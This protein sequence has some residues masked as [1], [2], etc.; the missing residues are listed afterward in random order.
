MTAPRT[1]ITLTETS[2]GWLVERR[3]STVIV[4][5]YALHDALRA[6]GRLARLHDLGAADLEPGDLD[7]LAEAMADDAIEARP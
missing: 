4:G 3:V 1:A 7:D 6:A 2:A 5:P